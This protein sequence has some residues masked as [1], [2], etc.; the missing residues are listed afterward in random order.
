MQTQIDCKI[1]LRTCIQYATAKFVG[2]CKLFSCPLKQNCL[3]GM[4]IVSDHVGY[5]NSVLDSVVKCLHVRVIDE[6]VIPIPVHTG[7]RVT[8]NIRNF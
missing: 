4:K 2:T 6:L 8:C 5:D 7:Q 1:V 3:P